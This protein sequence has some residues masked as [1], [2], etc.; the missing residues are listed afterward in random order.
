MYF[1]KL[2]G[3]IYINN[4]RQKHDVRG[5]TFDE[6]QYLDLSNIVLTVVKKNEDRNLLLP[7]QLL[8]DADIELGHSIHCKK[9]WQIETYPGGTNMTSG[10]FQQH[11]NSCTGPKYAKTAGF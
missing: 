4:R 8:P 1:G 11:G 7:R 9:T 10:N 2:Y 5:M 3:V 6:V